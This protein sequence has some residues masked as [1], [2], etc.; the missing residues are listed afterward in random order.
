MK[1][2]F[3]GM[4]KNDYACAICEVVKRKSTCDRSQV[5]VVILNK[6][7][8]IISTGYNGAP[9]NRPNCGEEGHLMEEGHCVRTIHAEINAIAQCAKSGK[10]CLDAIMYVTYVPCGN[11]AK[12]I[13]Q[14]GIKKVYA[15][16][17]RYKEGYNLL[18]ASNIIVLDWQENKFNVN[19]K[20][21]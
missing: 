20:T 18:I 19:M 3:K 16:Q 9:K 14:A 1:N 7:Y 13:I 10:S 12:L 17:K 15:K 6:D 21:T 5:G 2:E 11:C 8:E 4:S